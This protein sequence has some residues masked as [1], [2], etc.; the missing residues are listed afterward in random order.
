LRVDMKE[1]EPGPF[2]E[3]LVAAEGFADGKCTTIDGLRVDFSD[4]WG[5][6]RATNTT[7]SLVMRFEG[8]DKDAL[9]RIQDEFRQA[10]AAIYPNLELPF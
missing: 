4:R 10:V 9:A 7:P 6:V 5:L 1:G 8:D 3:K 2:V